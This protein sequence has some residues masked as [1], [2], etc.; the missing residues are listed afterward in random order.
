[1]GY[2]KDFRLLLWKVVL[3][4]KRKP[5]STLLELLLPAIFILI[6]VVLRVCSNKQIQHE[7]YVWKPF[8][9]DEKVPVIKDI[10]ERE[11]EGLWNL[12]YYPPNP[13]FSR[14]MERVQGILTY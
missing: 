9:V 6:L 13:Y 1:M 2:W 8:K 14:L 7:K 10:I 11:H 3:L 4:Q 12:A 5:I